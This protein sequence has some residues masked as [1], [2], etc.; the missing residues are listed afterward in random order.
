LQRKK[1][2]YI[3]SDAPIAAILQKIVTKLGVIFI[4]NVRLFFQVS[5][6]WAGQDAYK[7]PEG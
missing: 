2:I 4:G 6:L 1:K 7:F 5:Q 3:L